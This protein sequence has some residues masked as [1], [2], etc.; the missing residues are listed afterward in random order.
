VIEQSQAKL[1]ENK[2]HLV[3]DIPAGLLPVVGDRKSLERA[4]GAILDNAIKFSYEEGQVEV[5]AGQKD[6]QV[7]VEIRDHGVGIPEE[8]Q[9]RIFERFFHIDQIEGR[10]FRGLGLGLSIARQ[11]F[12]QHQ[13]QIQ[14]DSQ[15]GSGTTVRVTLNASDDGLEHS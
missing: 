13:G 8:I 9:S 14:V 3:T 10:M 4:F 15:L 7:W 2:I 5:A 6:A 12:E 11:V 1:A